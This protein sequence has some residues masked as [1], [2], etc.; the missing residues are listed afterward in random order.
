[1]IDIR[2]NMYKNQNAFVTIKNLMPAYM[3]VSIRQ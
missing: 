3:C 1:M 2:N